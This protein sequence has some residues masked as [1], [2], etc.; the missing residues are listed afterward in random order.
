MIKKLI[1]AEDLKEYVHL[2]ELAQRNHRSKTVHLP[3]SDKMI[4]TI[5][6]SEHS[7]SSLTSQI[8]KRLRRQFESHE[9]YKIDGKEVEE[10]EEWM[11]VALTFFADDVDEDMEDHNDPLVLTFPVSGW[12]I[13]KIFIYG[14]SSVNVLVYDTFKRM[15]LND[16]HLMFSYYIIYGFNREVSK[17]LEDI[18]L[19]VKEGP[20]KLSTR[21]SVVDAPS[22]YNVII[23]RRWV[24]LLKGVAATYH[25][26]LRFPTRKEK[27]R[28]KETKLPQQS[29]RSKIPSST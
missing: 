7:G 18:I 13:K 5:S 19:K 20:M 21:F 26:Y 14:G 11:N 9:I 22:P 16:E 29:A 25:Q 3:E 6:H 8:S 12:N 2:P 10:H 17:P 27:W 4:N 1:D 15:K 24:H 23:G 28:S